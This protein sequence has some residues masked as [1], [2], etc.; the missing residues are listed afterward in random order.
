MKVKI[1]FCCSI[2]LCCLFISLSA[3]VR[4]VRN[5][6]IQIPDWAFTPKYTPKQIYPTPD[7]G[8]IILGDCEVCWGNP[9]FPNHAADAGAIKLDA[10]GNCVW[11]WWSRDFVGSGPPRIVGIDQEADGRINFLINNS[12]DYNQ[13]GW[14]EPQENYFLQQIQWSTSRSF[15]IS[16]AMRLPDNTIFAIGEIAT[17]PHLSAYIAHLSA[18]GDT[19]STRTYPPDS[20]WTNFTHQAD[21][22]DME[23]D[24]DGMPVIV[25]TFSDLYGTVIKTDWDGNIIWRRNT[26]KPCAYL[27]ISMSK[28]PI[29]NEL[30]IGYPV[31]IT[32]LQG[33]FEFNKITDSGLDSLFS[34]VINYY[35]Y[36]FFSLVCHNQGIYLAGASQHTQVSI[37]NYSFSSNDEWTWTGYGYDRCEGTERVFIQPDSS[38]IYAYSDNEFGSALDIVK[39]NPDGTGNNDHTIPELQSILSVYPNPMKSNLHIEINSNTK[40]TNKEIHIYNSKGQLVKQINAE[41]KSH[42]M[43]SCYWDGKD[44]HGNNCVSG[45][46]IVHFKNESTILTKKLMII[47]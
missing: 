34:A 3:Q 40:L 43:L 29:T 4:Y 46:Y 14:I 21:A 16:R 23:L 36:S 20:L 32:D 5:I 37:A 26:N 28:V 45:M 1:I 12:P 25:C 10:Y 11:Q 47:K 18:Q 9:D 33:Y 17:L 27:N 8:V 44:M 30:I 19:L 39:L 41:N 35:T 7:G 31:K 42:N 15:G 13:I 2:L 24:T 22:H 6:P 38:I